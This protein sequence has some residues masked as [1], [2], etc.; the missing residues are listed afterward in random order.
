ML[1]IFNGITVFAC[2]RV[3]CG[4]GNKTPD[5]YASRLFF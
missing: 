5:L 2:G 3:F 1:L 4:G